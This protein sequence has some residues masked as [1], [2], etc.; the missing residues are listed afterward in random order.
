MALL[1]L[2]SISSF[3]ALSTSQQQAFLSPSSIKSHQQNNSLF[4]FSAT[5]TKGRLFS[6]STHPRKFLCKPPQGK[7]VREDYLVVWSKQLPFFLIICL[8]SFFGISL[9]WKLDEC[10]VFDWTEEED[11]SR[12]P[13]AGKRREKCTHYYWFLC[14]L[15]WP[16]YFNGPSDWIGMFFFFFF[17]IFVILMHCLVKFFLLRD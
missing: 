14:N 17:P 12:N 15:V 11:S 3:S 16:L 8:F 7:Y 2:N 4:S 9:S 1:Q 10:Y 6:F 5:A 13:G